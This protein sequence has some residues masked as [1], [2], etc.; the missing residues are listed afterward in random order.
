MLAVAC[1]VE[2]RYVQ[3]SQRCDVLDIA[4]SNL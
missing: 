3:T 4:P 1:E 2:W